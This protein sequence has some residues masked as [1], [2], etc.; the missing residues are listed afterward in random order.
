MLKIFTIEVLILWLKPIAF[1]RQFKFRILILCILMLFSYMQTLYG[2]VSTPG[3]RPANNKIPKTIITGYI[4]D[5]H[6]HKKAV[7]GAR[8]LSSSGQS[9]TTNQF[10][11]YQIG[12]YRGDTVR[13][14]T[15]QGTLIATYPAAYLQFYQS[16]N[17]YVEQPEFYLD[18]KD[19]GHELTTVKVTGRDYRKDSAMLRYLYS[20]IFNYKKPTIGDAIRVPKIG[21]VPIPLAIGVSVS[22]LIRAL[23][24][25]KNNSELRMKEF[26]HDAEDEGYIN[27]RLSSAV[28][29]LY[30]GIKEEDSIGY[31][32]LY[33]RPTANRLREMN[34]LE[35]GQYLIEQAHDFRIGK[36]PSGAPAFTQYLKIWQEADSMELD[37]RMPLD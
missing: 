37:D 18:N 14:Y 32:R 10:G 9:A 1:L 17:V 3:K 11:F 35:L 15:P 24:N 4:Y 28:I 6:T 25:K 33:Y 30:T 29:E 13:Y 16:L 19:M 20:D 36:L 26:A 27:H 34:D 8:I 31:F 22:G 23:Q 5:S 12:I 2:Q 21:K 7:I